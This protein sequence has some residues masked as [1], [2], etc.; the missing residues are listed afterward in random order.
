MLELPRPSNLRLAPGVQAELV[1]SDMYSICDRVREID[2]RLYIVALSDEDKHSYVVMEQTPHGDMLVTKVRELDQRIVDKL[3]YILSKPMSQR[4]REL[5]LEEERWAAQE[6][7]REMDE[8]IEN[9]ALPMQRQL[10]QD[11]FIDSRHT[12]MPMVT[13]RRVRRGG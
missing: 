6:Q 4:V 1:D 11:G 3:G 8:M 10:W 2:P 13:N 5:E 9:V 7:K 12:N